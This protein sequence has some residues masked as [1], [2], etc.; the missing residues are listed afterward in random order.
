MEILILG[1]ILVALMVYASTK[2]KKSAASAFERETIE[3]AEFS[4]VKPEGF[5]YPLNEDSEFAF[6]AYSKDFGTDAAEKLKQ[7]WMTLRIYPGLELDELARKA[8]A[9]AAEIISEE[10]AENKGVKIY[11]LNIEG[12]ERGIAVEIFY[13]I[14]ERDEKT[15][16]LRVSVLPEYKTDYSLRIRETLTSFSVK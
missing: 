9:D 5:I 3:T 4:V 10:T 1:V 6:E 13:K 12:S 16:E 14:T 8:K 7:S 2:I 11:V 15:Y